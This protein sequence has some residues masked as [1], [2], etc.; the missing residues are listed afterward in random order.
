MSSEPAPPPPAGQPAVTHFAFSHRALTLEGVTFTLSPRSRQPVMQIAM[1]D[2]KGTI[3]LARIAET[4]Q[5]AVGSADDRLLK[6]VERSL[7]HVHQIRNGD[8]IPNEILDGTAS[9]PINDRHRR[10]AALKVADMV[11]RQILGGA[12]AEL[13]GDDATDQVRSRIKEAAGDVAEKIGLPR[14]RDWEALDRI[15]TL[16]NE[17][18]FIEALRDYWNPLF[19]MPRKLRDVQK[20]NRRDRDLSDQLGSALSLIKAPVAQIRAIFD[21]VDRT[22]ADPVAAFSRYEQ[23]LKVLRARRDSLHFETLRWG[24]VPGTWRA[25]RTDDDAG[26]V[27]AS[28][29]YRFLVQNYMRTTAWVGAG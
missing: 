19:D 4:F 24:E 28:R 18:A 17:M 29:L 21:D 11:I 7:R 23:T 5:I 22:I 2:I 3:D 10:L 27:Q 15:E 14:S 8:R 1:G 25:L 26:V 20:A 9:W 6:I 12:Q 13:P 16:T